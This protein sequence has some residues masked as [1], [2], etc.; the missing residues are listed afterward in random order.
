LLR[1]ILLDLK[2]LFCHFLS[3]F[4]RGKKKESGV[5]KEK[6]RS[7][8]T[9]SLCSA[10][11]SCWASPNLLHSLLCFAHARGVSSRALFDRREFARLKRFGVAEPSI[12]SER[13]KGVENRV[14]SL[15]LGAFLSLLLDIKEKEMHKII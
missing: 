12:L 9:S 7:I 3:F 1:K 2:F 15:S 11:H 5:K 13:P 10:V 8:S 14:F 4:L 6:P